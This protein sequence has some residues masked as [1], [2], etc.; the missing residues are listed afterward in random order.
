MNVKHIISETGRIPFTGLTEHNSTAYIPES[1]AENLKFAPTTETTFKDIIKTL[2]NATE[3]SVKINNSLVNEDGHVDEQAIHS[4]FKSESVNFS[5]DDLDIDINEDPTGDAIT[6]VTDHI[7]IIDP[8]RQALD[9]LGYNCKYHWN[10][11]KSYTI[12]NP[13]DGYYPLQQILQQKGEGENVFGWVDIRDYGG[14]IDIYLLLESHKLYPGTREEN[15]GSPIYLGFQTGYDFSGGRAFDSTLFGYDTKHDTWLFNL[16]PRKSR[17]H[18]GKVVD[19]TADIKSWWEKEYDRMQLFTDSILSDIDYAET[20]QID[21]N[22][23]EFSIE[24]FYHYLGIPWNDR[25]TGYTTDAAKLARKYSD[26]NTVSAWS[27]AYALLIT[28]EN[29]YEAQNDG[30]KHNSATFRA[31]V[32]IAT[33][34]IRKP[35][36]QIEKVVNEKKKREQPDGESETDPL[37]SQLGSINVEEEIAGVQSNSPDVLARKGSALQ[38]L[39]Q[40]HLGESY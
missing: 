22:T 35:D 1:I 40:K 20:R 37:Q 6:D 4:I 39:Q 25:E 12:V 17:K 5:L 15:D 14:A 33:N 21:F 26:E 24:E 30:H 28:L 8:R 11:G 13:T 7:A 3:E 34:I 10:I 16:G 36:K 2:P 27:L 32:E 38:N 31:Y 19:A 9:A 18:V 29:D 23:S